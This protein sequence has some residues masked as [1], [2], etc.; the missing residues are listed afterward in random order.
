[1]L[2]AAIL[3]KFSELGRYDE[4]IIAAEADIAHYS[5]F[6]PASCS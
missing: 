5:R 1:M 3:L 6:P 4:A 2:V